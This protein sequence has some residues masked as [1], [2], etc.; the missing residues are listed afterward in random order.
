MGGINMPQ[1]LPWRRRA[2]T[3]VELLVVIGI[4]ALLIA[5]LLPALN[6][7]REGAKRTQCL[8][9]ERQLYTSMLMYS[10]SYNDAVPI[11]CWGTGST[12]YYQQNYMVW[13][14]GQ[15]VPIMFGLLWSTEYLKEPTAFF[16]PSDVDPDDVFNSPSNPWPP[17]PLSS[18]FVNWDPSVNS[19][20][21]YASRPVDYNGNP[22]QWTGSTP[23]P[24]PAT[25]NG[26]PGPIVFPKLSKYKNL[27]ILADY[28][29]SPQSLLVR[30]I[31]GINVLYGNGGAIWV[32]SSTFKTDL[33]QCNQSFSTSYNPDELNVWKD[34]DNAH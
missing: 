30:H 8:S 25:I 1:S 7:A 14:E 22:V 34:L 11:G 26:V 12:P 23:W 5:I 24:L 4:I 29:S 9:N 18:A 33:N 16:C 6:K 17:D 15:Q 21:G 19:R 2:F 20:V 32:D 31:A 3:L 27:A 13:R 10:E 28:V